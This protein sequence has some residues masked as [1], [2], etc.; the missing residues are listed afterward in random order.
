MDPERLKEWRDILRDFAIIAVA[1]FAAVYAITAIREPTIL[2]PVLFFS[3]ALFGLP[4]FIRWD[5]SR[6][7]NGEDGKDLSDW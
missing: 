7:K 4:P 3:G 2:G 6:R 1:I 5:S